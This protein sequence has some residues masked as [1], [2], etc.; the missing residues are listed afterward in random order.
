MAQRKRVRPDRV[1]GVDLAKSQLAL[2]EQLIAIR[3]A[4]GLTQRDV[5]RK[6]GLPDHTSVSKFENSLHSDKHPNLLTVKRYAE[7]VGAYVA[8]F[9]TDGSVS[10]EGE[11]SYTGTNDLLHSHTKMLEDV[12]EGIEKDPS[13]A[14]RIMAETFSN[15]LFNTTFYLVK[16]RH[17]RVKAT[18]ERADRVQHI[19]SG[20][21]P[22]AS[23]KKLMELINSSASASYP[24][25]IHETVPVSSKISESVEAPGAKPLTGG[26]GEVSEERTFQAKPI[27]RELCSQ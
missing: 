8:H 12:A 23:D 15:E 7:A 18:I 14:S 25:R 16:N 6:M 22:S 9:V 17:S 20:I 10:N 27:R 21:L 19:T 26:W 11:R 1:L 4:K 13:H 2:I 3:K 24:A 5:A